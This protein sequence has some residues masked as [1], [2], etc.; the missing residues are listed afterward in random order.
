MT[1]EPSRAEFHQIFN[2]NKADFSS[3]SDLFGLLEINANALIL[4]KLR[5]L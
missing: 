3:L 4:N 5:I 2:H 1:D